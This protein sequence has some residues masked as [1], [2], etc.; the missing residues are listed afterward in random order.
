VALGIGLAYGS[1]RA[2]NELHA[3]DAR[4]GSSVP[5]TIVWA[6]GWAS[7]SL[8]ASPVIALFVRHWGRLGRSGVLAGMAV[9]VTV[10]AA[11][12]FHLA[13]DGSL[14]RGPG[15]D[16]WRYLFIVS[17][18][19]ASVAVSAMLRRARLVPWWPT[20]LIGGGEALVAAHYLVLNERGDI[21]V[22]AG[23][24]LLAIGGAAFAVLLGRERPL[25]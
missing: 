18:A 2:A 3:N 8:I 10:L 21:A 4:L 11:V 1:L 24:V 16:R 13:N 7:L 17:G 25:A 19:V 5:Y 22:I 12:G 6:A 20:V 23:I 14:S 9:S 15:P